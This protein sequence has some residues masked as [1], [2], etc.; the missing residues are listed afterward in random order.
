MRENHWHAHMLELAKQTN[1]APVYEAIKTLS[2]VDA[3]VV[4][5]YNISLPQGYVRE[6][7]FPGDQYVYTGVK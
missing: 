2:P 4:D 5:A 6:S 3:A 1:I 7:K